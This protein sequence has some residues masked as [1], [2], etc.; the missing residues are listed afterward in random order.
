MEKRKPFPGEEL[1]RGC[2]ELLDREWELVAVPR[3]L[4]PLLSWERNFFLEDDDSK[5]RS[6]LEV[7]PKEGST[8]EFF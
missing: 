6:E 2:L 8:K 1:E 3:V 7:L 4:L 5:V